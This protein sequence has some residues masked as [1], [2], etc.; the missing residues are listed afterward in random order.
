M[1]IILEPTYGQ[2]LIPQSHIAGRLLGKLGRHLGRQMQESKGTDTIL[3]RG[4]D[5]IAHRGHYVRIVDIQRGRAGHKAAAIDPNQD[6]QSIGRVLWIAIVYQ[7]LCILCLLVA[8]M[9]QE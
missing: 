1:C 6:G 5:H 3:K 8:R 2:C 9:L 4:N 7:V